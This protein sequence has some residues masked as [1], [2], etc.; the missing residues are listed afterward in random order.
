MSKEKKCVVKNDFH[1]NALYK[2]NWFL[3][4]SFVLVLMPSHSTPFIT[5][6]FTLVLPPL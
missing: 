4:F 3:S 1:V 5:L 6:S 2:D